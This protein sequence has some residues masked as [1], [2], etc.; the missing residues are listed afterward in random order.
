VGPGERA[1]ISIVT[2]AIWSGSKPFH[3]VTYCFFSQSTNFFRASAHTR[4]RQSTELASDA[5][6]PSRSAR[7]REGGDAF[8]GG[9]QRE[10]EA[11]LLVVDE[12]YRRRRAAVPRDLAKEA[13]ARCEIGEEESAV[14]R[15]LG[16]RA[17]AHD[18]LGHHTQRALRP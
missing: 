9:L 10:A 2:A 1:S 18:R 12:A 17:D 7:A 6:R 11:E 3:L 13:H 8:H 5:P 15:S 16:K 4:A 14:L